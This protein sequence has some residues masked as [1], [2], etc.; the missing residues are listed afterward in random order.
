MND[1][2]G[3]PGDV[4]YSQL[5]A[6]TPATNNQFSFTKLFEGVIV[7][8]VFYLGYRQPSSGSLRI[9]LDKGNNTSAMMYDYVNGTWAPNDRI[10]GSL[11]IRP[12]FG[13]GDVVTGIP[14]VINPVSIYP[15][16]S[17]GSFYVKGPVENLQI[18]SITGQPVDIKIENLETEKSITTFNTPAGIYIVRYQSGGRVFT[19]KIVIR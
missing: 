5:V 17:A 19:E 6:I 13:P 9:G 16:P 3:A 18:I 10:P 4:I 1:N 11:M 2:N 8:D 14:E 7:E 15:N 12:H